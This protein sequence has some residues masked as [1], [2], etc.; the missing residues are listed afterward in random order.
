MPRATLA[1]VNREP[2]PPL[3]RGT[4]MVLNAIMKPFVRPHWSGTEK[5]P[6]VGGAVIAVNHISNA[7]P[8]AVGQFLAYSGR[9]PYFLAKASLFTI[10]GF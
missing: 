10:P 8:L 3:L 7:D 5:L 9:W 6:P 1:I 2:A 4:V